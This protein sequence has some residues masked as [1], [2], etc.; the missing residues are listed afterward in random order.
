MVTIGRNSMLLALCNSIH[1]TQ[2]CEWKCYFP[3]D[4]QIH[5]P[6]LP[7]SAHIPFDFPFIVFALCLYAHYSDDL[8]VCTRYGLVW[9]FA[10][11][12]LTHLCTRSVRLF[13]LALSRVNFPPSVLCMYCAIVVVR[14]LLHHQCVCVCVYVWILF[15]RNPVDFWLYFHEN[16]WAFFSI[17]D[18]SLNE[19]HE[20]IPNTRRSTSLFVCVPFEIHRRHRANQPNEQSINNIATDVTHKNPAAAGSS[21]GSAIN[22]SSLV[23]NVFPPESFSI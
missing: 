6:E 7:P 8:C 21:I 19:A 10:C 5:F 18:K 22:D 23:G 14:V 13:C 3:S 11:F 9:F 16:F 1:N 4:T 15:A 20:I 12:I 2:H 17:P